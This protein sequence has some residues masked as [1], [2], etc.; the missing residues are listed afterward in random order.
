MNLDQCLILRRSLRQVHAYAEQ[1]HDKDDVDLSALLY[2]L[3][4]QIA[5]TNEQIRATLANRVAFTC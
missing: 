1:I 4:D 5:I 2:C 3:E